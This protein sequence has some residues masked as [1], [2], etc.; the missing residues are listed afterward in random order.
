MSLAPG[1]MLVL[2]TDGFYE[3]EN[4]EGEDF[5]FARLEKVIRESCDY[6]PGEVIKRL[7]SSVISFCQGTKQMDALTAVVL[8]RKVVA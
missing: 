7:H 1:D 3:W 8:K 5:G 2:V 4:P 6:S